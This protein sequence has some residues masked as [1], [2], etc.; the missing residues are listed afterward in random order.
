M[1]DVP[2]PAT[3]GTDDVLF[4]SNGADVLWRGQVD[5]TFRSTAVG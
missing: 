5:G 2:P 3:P 1:M 4:V